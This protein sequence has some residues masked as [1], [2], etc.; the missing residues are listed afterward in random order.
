[1]KRLFI[2][3]MLLLGM[4]LTV[5]SCKKEKK[6]QD[7]ITRKVVEKKAPE[8]IQKMSDYSLD[9]TIDWLGGSYTVSIHRF[10]D[11]KLPLAADES[12]RKYYDNKIALKVIRADGSIF[13]ER[14]FV[15]NDF[16]EYVNKGYGDNGA[17]LGLVFDRV[18][19][20]NMY[21]GASVGSPDTMSDEYIPLVVVL[22]K[23][24][25]VRIVK[26]TQM[27]TGNGDGGRMDELEAAEAEGV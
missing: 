27:D 8:G 14:V 12:G 24:G 25:N 16:K 10:P 22:S 13:Y 7:I 11:G 21:F 1:M 5:S 15:K 20:G 18:D 2:P 26:D 19:G 3:V 23:T 6:T 4:L 9:K 17:L